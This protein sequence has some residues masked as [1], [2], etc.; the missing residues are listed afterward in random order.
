MLQRQGLQLVRPRLNGPKGFNHSTIYRTYMA[1]G[2]LQRQ[3][4]D[5]HSLDLTG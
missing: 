4:N 3:L 1:G 5:Q 2:I